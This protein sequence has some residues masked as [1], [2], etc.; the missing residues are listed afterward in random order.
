[1]MA[2]KKTSSFETLNTL[3]MT[4]LA[5]TFFVATL[6]P[7]WGKYIEIFQKDKMHFAESTTL[8]IVTFILFLRY[9]IACH[10]ELG[11]LADHVDES[12]APRIRA[13]TYVVIM[14]LALF[15]GVLISV[16]D[17][18]L[19]YAVLIVIYNLIDLWGGFQ[20]QKILRPLIDERIG[21]EKSQQEIEILRTIDCYYFQNPTL[22]R[23]VTIMFVNWIAV[24][25]A[26]ISSYEEKGLS[27]IYRDIAY[28]ILVLNIII[29]ELFIFIWR[30]KRDN[31]IE[32]IERDSSVNLKRK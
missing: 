14:S 16:S 22:Q 6:I 17:K 1:M 28:L 10:Y 23:I 24:C 9:A 29:S 26:L 21:A 7:S 27:Q 13:K 4:A 25:S 15:F 18:I 2:D 11:M 32:R 31:A 3:W 30:K 19:I 12:S 20:V 5:I 8:A